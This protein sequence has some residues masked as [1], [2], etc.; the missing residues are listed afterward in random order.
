VFRLSFFFY[1]SRKRK[2]PTVPYLHLELCSPILF[3]PHSLY[4]SKQLSDVFDMDILLQSFA[5][6]SNGKVF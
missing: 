5:I 3:S 4:I 1:E 6:S 2:K